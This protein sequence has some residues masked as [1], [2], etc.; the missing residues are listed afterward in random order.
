MRE[1]T[2]NAKEYLSR[3]ENL[4]FDAKKQTISLSKFF[5]WY[6]VD[7]GQVNDQVS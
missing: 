5:K 7:F 2:E 3:E 6:A 1:M 4:W